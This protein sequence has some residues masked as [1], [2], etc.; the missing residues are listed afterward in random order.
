M[1]YEV[2][3]CSSFIIH[4]S[5]LPS[6]P[7]IQALNFRHPAI[8]EKQ[9]ILKPIRAKIEGPVINDDCSDYTAC[10]VIVINYFLLMLE[11]IGGLPAFAYYLSG[12]IADRD[13]PPVTI[14]GA[15]CYSVRWDLHCGDDEHYQD[16]DKSRFHIPSVCP[17]PSIA[18]GQFD[19]G[20]SISKDRG[21]TQKVTNNRKV[22]VALSPLRR[23]LH[24][25]CFLHLPNR[26]SFCTNHFLLYYVSN[27]HKRNMTCSENQ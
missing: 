15:R 2:K 1:N 21:P 7:V 19:V 10:R 3:P 11:S 18:E 20:A 6:I 23:P 5:S 14:H 9:T 27:K 25:G 16:R 26:R 22:R 24:P 13:D 12:G 8:H 17:G 4:T